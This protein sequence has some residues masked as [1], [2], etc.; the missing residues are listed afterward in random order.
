MKIKYKGIYMECNRKTCFYYCI[1][2]VIALIVGIIFSYLLGY[3]WLSYQT[4]RYYSNDLTQ[5]RAVALSK[6]N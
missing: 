4:E 3:I 2:I 5:Q 1:M 6:I